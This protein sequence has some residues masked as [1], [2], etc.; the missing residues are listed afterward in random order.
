MRRPHS[1]SQ[2]NAWTQAWTGPQSDGCHHEDPMPL[3]GKIR[4]TASSPS[5][6]GYSHYTV[7]EFAMPAT[8]VRTRFILWAWIDFGEGRCSWERDR[9][10]SSRKAQQQQQ[11]QLRRTRW[12]RAE[13]P[14]ATCSR[15]TYWALVRTS[16]LCYASSYFGAVDVCLNC[17][18]SECLMW[19]VAMKRWLPYFILFYFCFYGVYS[20]LIGC[21]SF[22]ELGIDVDHVVAWFRGVI[23]MRR[24]RVNKWAEWTRQR[25]IQPSL[26][27]NFRMWVEMECRR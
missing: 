14:R 11:Q 7:V 15:G 12:R 17:L 2:A 8:L 10:G 5:A 1:P 25:L 20:N 9:Q 27:R 4:P 13:F 6:T 21:C 16:C 23:F 18:V 3:F 22:T 19:R 24:E 26:L